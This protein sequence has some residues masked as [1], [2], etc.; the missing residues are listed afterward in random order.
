ML[1]TGEFLIERPFG[2]SLDGVHNAGQCL[3]DYFLDPLGRQ[4]KHVGNQ[5]LRILGAR[6]AH[7]IV[8]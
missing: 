7:C 5:V 4:V 1:E 2:L 8:A 3:A 6:S